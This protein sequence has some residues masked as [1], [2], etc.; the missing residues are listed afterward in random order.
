MTTNEAVEQEKTKV[1]LVDDHPIVRD[2]LKTLIERRENYVVCGEAENAKGALKG[3]KE[4]D[5]D[6]V[7]TDITLKES[8]GLELTKD[9]KV[10]YPDLP[11]IVLSIHEE[12][13]YAERALRAGAQG[14]LMKEVASENV[15]DAL[16]TVLQGELYISN[17][18][19][20]RFLNKMVGGKATEIQSPVE[21]LSDRELE[22]F[23]LI[24]QGFKASQIAERLHLSV[25]TV[26]TYRARIKEKLDL[27]DAGELLQFAI[28][29]SSS[30]MG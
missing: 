4:S 26:E 12:S 30:N 7:I 1:F 17:T 6:V 25:K 15:M 2:G 5:P 18:M 19:A 27:A 22:I 11:V 9:L 3:V 10:R 29:W 28:K 16:N 23:K 14:Y 8:D 21:T 13:T 24:G 20:K